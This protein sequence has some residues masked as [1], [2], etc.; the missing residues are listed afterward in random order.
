MGLIKVVVADD[1]IDFCNAIKEA[2]ETTDDMSLTGIANNG[3]EAFD[4]IMETRPDLVLLDNVMPYLDGIGVMEKL[5]MTELP[6]RPKIITFSSLCSDDFVKAMFRLGVNYCMNKNVDVYQ[7]LARGRMLVD[8]SL[9]GEDDEYFPNASG[10]KERYLSI[11]TD[12]LH[13]LGI[14]ANLKGYEYLRRAVLIAVADSAALNGVTKIIYPQIAAEYKTD[15][16]NVE[17]A[18]RHAI[19]ISWERSNS[20]T[21]AEFF[22]PIVDKRKGRPTNSETIATLAQYVINY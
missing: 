4:L 16:Y 6:K 13:K 1:N 10:S 22:K 14:P 3:N 9:C 17:R 20:E 2:I 5:N 21:F 11:I 19:K 12:V 18:I 15:S 8:N 7:I